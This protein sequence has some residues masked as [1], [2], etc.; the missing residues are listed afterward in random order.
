MSKQE[1]PID[2]RSVPVGHAA[3]ICAHAPD[4]PMIVSFIAPDTA[5]VPAPVSAR[6][7]GEQSA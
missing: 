4:I 5:K 6:R 3:A 2:V 1:R 7:T